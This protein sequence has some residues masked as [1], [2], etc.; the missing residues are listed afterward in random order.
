MTIQEIINQLKN[1]KGS[2]LN[3]EINTEEL[4][5]GLEDIIHEVEGNDGLE[6]M[7]IADDDWSDTFERVDFTQLKV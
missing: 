2:Y 6:G 1:V 4:I 7:M 3:D 5:E